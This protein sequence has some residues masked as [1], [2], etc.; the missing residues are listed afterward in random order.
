MK[1]SN[2]RESRKKEKE[3]EI[4]LSNKQYEDAKKK[5]IKAIAEMEQCDSDPKS[6]CELYLKLGDVNLMLDDSESAIN[7]YSKYLEAKPSGASRLV[8]AKIHFLICIEAYHEHDVTKLIKVSIDM[9][10]DLSDSD[11]KHT[12]NTF[13]DLVTILIIYLPQEKHKFNELLALHDK[14]THKSSPLITI[15]LEAF[16]QQFIKNIQELS[17]QPLNGEIGLFLAKF[18]QLL[19]NLISIIGNNYRYANANAMNFLNKNIW[20]L[21]K[22]DKIQRI[23]TIFNE[24]IKFNNLKYSDPYELCLSIG[25]FYMILYMFDISIYYFKECKRLLNSKNPDKRL[26][27]IYDN[28]GT[29]FC[30]KQEFGKSINYYKKSLA[31][32]PTKD[33]NIKAKHFFNVGRCYQKKGC[34]QDAIHY[35]GQALRIV[36]DPNRRQILDTY[37]FDCNFDLGDEKRI[38]DCI[39]K[40]C[41]F[42]DERSDNKNAI[43]N[44]A[45]EF[46]TLLEDSHIPKTKIYENKARSS[47]ITV[48][49]KSYDHIAAKHTEKRITKKFKS[50][51]GASIEQGRIEYELFKK[52]SKM[53]N[54]F[55][56]VYGP[57]KEKLKQH[58]HIFRIEMEACRETLED[59]F[60]QDEISEVRIYKIIQNIIEGLLI[61]KQKRLV[62]GDVSPKNILVTFYNEIKI[63]DFGNT[64]KIN[65][66]DRYVVFVPKELTENYSSPEIYVC[67]LLRNEHLVC[68]PCKCDVFSLGLTILSVIGAPI[69]GL[70]DLLG[71]N[72]TEGQRLIIKEVNSKGYSVL[73]GTLNQEKNWYYQHMNALQMKINDI[74]IKVRYESLRPLIEKMLVVNYE[75]RESYDQLLRFMSNPD[76]I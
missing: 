21:N 29:L 8:L 38:H 76:R 51:T 55:L 54:Q 41:K 47:G 2:L 23:Q 28:L 32:H 50:R 20:D 7:E 69:N 25:Y 70:N 53:G 61:M 62:H 10:R 24:I 71:D 63:A 74:I 14:I 18:Q 36:K 49:I 22:P 5:F 35:Y 44:T 46:S 3:G 56:K 9:I 58:Q 33:L 40:I 60:E 1:K 17:K 6:Y 13:K 68:N 57:T 48:S 43:D 15:M 19:E 11:C 31:S 12:G 67:H 39:L 65:E 42:Y 30:R 52:L 72:L 16:V 37:I 4:C 59:Y 75:L 27:E 73:D 66:T 64:K 26:S 34:L 45:K